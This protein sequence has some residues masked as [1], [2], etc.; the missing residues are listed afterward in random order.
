MIST[1][2]AST[3]KI[4]PNKVTS[5]DLL[6]TAAVVL[7][8]IDHIGMFFFPDIMAFRIIGRLS[9]PIWLFLIG[10]AKTREITLP[11]M[12][13]ALILIG[14]QTLTTGSPLPLDILVTIMLVRLTIDKVAPIMLRNTQTLYMAT[15]ALMVVGMVTILL[16]DYGAVALLPAILGY[17]C[18]RKKLFPSRRSVITI[19]LSCCFGYVFVQSFVVSFN[20]LRDI[21]IAAIGVIGVFWLLMD[22]KPKAYPAITGFSKQILMFCGRNTLAIYVIHLA[23]FQLIAEYLIP[24]LQG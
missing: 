11:L 12:F 8:I 1:P 16:F 4:L 14:T 18:R 9:A 7:M 19:M 15:I 24:R 2:S 23:A 20:E 3:K 22:F 10:F 21:A 17:C 13:G 6:K 5:Y